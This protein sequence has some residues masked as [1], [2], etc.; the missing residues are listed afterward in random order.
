M[1]AVLEQKQVWQ[2][3][4]IKK[5]KQPVGFLAG[6]FGCW[7]KELSRPFT[8]KNESYRVCTNC[9]ARRQFDPET[10]QTHGHFY[11]PHETGLAHLERN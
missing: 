11:F 4:K 2:K 5:D 6:I 3:E 9:G 1:E 8:T 10:L 7:H